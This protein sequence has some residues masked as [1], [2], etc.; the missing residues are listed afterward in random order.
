MKGGDI[1]KS[2]ISYKDRYLLSISETLSVK[3]ISL[4]LGVGSA[5]ASKIRSKALNY[6]IDND[7]PLYTQQVPTE[8]VL[9]VAGKSIDYYFN[10][11]MLEHKLELQ[12]A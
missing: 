9:I 3:E 5:S 1:M 8:A 11:Y 12:G 4:L 6:C 10:K 2:K 7:I